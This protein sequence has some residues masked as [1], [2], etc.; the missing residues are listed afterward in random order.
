M[1]ERMSI[2]EIFSITELRGN[3]VCHLIYKVGNI[4]RRRMYT[5]SEIYRKFD[6]RKILVYKVA[7]E[8]TAIGTTCYFYIKYDSCMSSA[9]NAAY[10]GFRR[11]FG[12]SMLVAEIPNSKHEMHRYGYHWD[13]VIPINKKAAFNLYRRGVEVYKLYPDNTEAEADDIKDIFEHDGLFGIEMH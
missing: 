6:I 5:V 8:E 13:G 9:E 11:E 10:Y 7:I 1:K 4:I 12:L 2:K 3:D